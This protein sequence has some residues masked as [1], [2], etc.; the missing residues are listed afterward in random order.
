[1]CSRAVKNTGTIFWLISLLCSLVHFEVGTILVVYFSPYGVGPINK[2]Y[3]SLLGV[4]TDKMVYLGPFW[5]FTINGKLRH[6]LGQHH[7]NGINNPFLE[8]TL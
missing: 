6:F 4:G 7:K 1:M 8:G 5:I 3:F 2:V